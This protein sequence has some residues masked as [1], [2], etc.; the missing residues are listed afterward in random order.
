MMNWTRIKIFG[1]LFG[2]FFLQIFAQTEH[3]DTL[4]EDFLVKRPEKL[5]FRQ[6]LISFEGCVQTTSTRLRAEAQKQIEDIIQRLKNGERFDHLCYLFSEHSSKNNLGVMPSFHPGEQLLQIEEALLKSPITPQS[7]IIGPVETP[8]GFHLLQRVGPQTLYFGEILLSHQDSIPSKNR[9]REETLLF[10]QKILQEIHEKNLPFE[11]AA[12]QYS[13]GTITQK[14][15]GYLG[16]LEVGFLPPQAEWILL[17]LPFENTAQTA[18]E[19]SSGF[20]IFKRYRFH[21]IRVRHLLFSYR[22][23]LSPMGSP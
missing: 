3:L 6:L 14:R 10:V 20:H 5:H 9:S 17:R 12:A 19:T 22:E 16:E 18:V 2:A 21:S 4:K 23:A 8:Y 7:P 1:T 11:L 13:E 15:M